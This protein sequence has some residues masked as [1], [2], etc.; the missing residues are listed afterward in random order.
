M[1][2]VVKNMEILHVRYFITARF[3]VGTS[4]IVN[5][6]MSVHLNGKM[7]KEQEIPSKQTKRSN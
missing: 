3:P 5:H 7:E 6:S 4:R 2:L 1:T